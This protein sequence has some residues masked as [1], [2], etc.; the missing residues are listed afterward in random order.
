MPSGSAD[1]VEGLAVLKV[2]WSAN[3]AKSLGDKGW[4]PAG[5]RNWRAQCTALA[6]RRRGQGIRRI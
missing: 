5:M 1:T 4:Q 3:A 2:Q 6:L